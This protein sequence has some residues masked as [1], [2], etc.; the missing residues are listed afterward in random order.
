M[1]SQDFVKRDCRHLMY[2]MDL[3]ITDVRR[4]LSGRDK[5]Q[6][7]GN[8]CLQGNKKVCC[9][10]LYV[11][12]RFLPDQRLTTL[13]GLNYSSYIPSATLRVES[14]HHHCKHLLVQCFLAITL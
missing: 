12:T 6:N 10:W 5:K 1:N 13:F 4:F 11:Q 8:K 7:R 2:L 3:L 9:T 14:N